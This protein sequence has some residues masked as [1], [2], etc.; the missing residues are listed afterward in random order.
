MK[1]VSDK[2]SLHPIRGL[3]LP[4]NPGSN[5]PVFLQVGGKT[6]LPVFS[7]KLKFSEAAKWG[8]FEDATSNVIVNPQDFYDCV[9][10]FKKRF[11]F[12]VVLDPY[13]T[14]EGNTRFQLLLYEEEKEN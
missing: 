7:D 6:L 5:G 3:L 4:I 1:P 2:R 10:M 12:H 11:P 8:K 14:E 9:I 13:I